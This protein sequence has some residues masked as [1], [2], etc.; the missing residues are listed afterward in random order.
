MWSWLKWLFYAP[1]PAVCGEGE[2]SKATVHVDCTALPDVRVRTAEQATAYAAYFCE[3]AHAYDA[4][5]AEHGRDAVAL[6][7]STG[8]HCSVA[9]AVVLGMAAG[10]FKT[11]ADGERWY[12]RQR[13]R[14]AQPLAFY[15]PAIRLAAEMV[16]AKLEV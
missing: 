3:R 5:V 4:A 11:E 7:C 2:P 1:Y 16:R 10:H 6:R 9:V 13:G 12:Q 14:S 8:L 15:R